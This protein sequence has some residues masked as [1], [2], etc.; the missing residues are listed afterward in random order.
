[1]MHVISNA[2]ADRAYIIR[3]ALDLNVARKQF[4]TPF[5]KAFVYHTTCQN[6]GQE[7]F[8]AQKYY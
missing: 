4:T 5:K 7:L 8:Y 3:L 2:I 6:Y 1:M